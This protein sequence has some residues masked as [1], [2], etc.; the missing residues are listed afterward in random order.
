MVF[1]SRSCPLRRQNF[2]HG[3]WNP[4]HYSLSQLIFAHHPRP[5]WPLTQRHSHSHHN[6]V[7]PSNHWL[8]RVLVLDLVQHF[9]S[10]LAVGFNAKWCR[11]NFSRMP[12]SGGVHFLVRVLVWSESKSP[13]T[14]W[15]YSGRSGSGATGQVFQ[16]TSLQLTQAQHH[17]SGPSD[18]GNWV[19]A[20]ATCRDKVFSFCSS[21]RSCSGNP[22]LF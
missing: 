18:F 1:L 3:L 8:P 9:N 16:F 21:A 10:R 13:R 11:S 15:N 4:P 2:G 22:V 12:D 7:T 20:L 5:I 6:G 19:T 17:A 14:H